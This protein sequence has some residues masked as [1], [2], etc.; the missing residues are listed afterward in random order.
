MTLDDLMNQR[1]SMIVSMHTLERILLS[2][3]C[4]NSTDLRLVDSILSTYSTL[5]DKLCKDY[6][7]EIYK[8]YHNSL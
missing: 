3:E 6:N 7:P 4:Q 1:Q 8:F 2:K 5:C